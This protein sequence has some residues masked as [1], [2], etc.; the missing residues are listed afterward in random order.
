ML[1]GIL[2]MYKP[3]IKY[4]ESEHAKKYSNAPNYFER[5]KEAVKYMHRQVGDLKIDSS[6]I[7]YMGLLIR[8]L[9]VTK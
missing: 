2:D 8:H 5:C 4:S 1:D 3:D 6:G 9:C 7:A